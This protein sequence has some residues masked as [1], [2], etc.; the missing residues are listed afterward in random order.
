MPLVT[1]GPAVRAATPGTRVTFDQ[2][3]AANAAVCSCRVSISRTFSAR[4]PSYIENRWPPE[5]VKI[6]SIPLAR[7]RRAIRCPALTVCYRSVNAH[8]GSIISACRR[9]RSRKCS[10][11]EPAHRPH[12]RH[13][14]DPTRHRLPNRRSAAGVAAVR[15]SRW[16]ATTY[17]RGIRGH[18]RTAAHHGRGLESGAIGDRKIQK[19]LIEVALSHL[20]IRIN[21]D[22]QDWSQ[23]L[24]VGEQQRIAF[25]RTLLSR[26]RV[27][28]LDESTSAMDE[29]L[30]LMLYELIHRDAR[31]QSR[32]REPPCH[33]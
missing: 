15:E 9:P 24:S 11:P 8:G 4:Q 22:A 20:V 25:A 18:G 19:T 3:S 7:R 33:R 31:D 13:R 30:E 23:A 10:S 27:V 1:P 16:R 14:T 21:D 32:K 2:P 28:F 29:G 5:R 26:P 6:V 17:A 12:R